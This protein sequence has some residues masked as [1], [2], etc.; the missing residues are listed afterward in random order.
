MLTG[1]LG[2]TIILTDGQAAAR[3]CGLNLIARLKKLAM[4]TSIE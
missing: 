3:Y 2:D 1:K 4:V